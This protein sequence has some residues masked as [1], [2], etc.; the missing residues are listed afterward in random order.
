MKNDSNIEEQAVKDSKRLVK[1]LRDIVAKAEAML[2]KAVGDV[3]EESVASLREQCAKSQARL[4]QL[5]SDTK[6]HCVDGAKRVDASVRA[7]PYQTL[8]IAAGVGLL[9]GLLVRRKLPAVWAD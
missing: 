5:F 4:G 1:D 2:K 8:A 3:T 7:K 6:N 9:L